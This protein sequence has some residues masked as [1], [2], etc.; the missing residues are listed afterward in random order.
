MR[1]VTDV[2][3]RAED[4][5]AQGRTEFEAGLGDGRGRPGA[6]GGNGVENGGSGNGAGYT[7]ARADQDQRNGE[8]WV[9]REE[10]RSHQ[11]QESESHDHQAAGTRSASAEA[12]YEPSDEN[13]NGNCG[14]RI[15]QL[16]QAGPK[17]R[18]FAHELEVLAEEVPQP[19]QCEDSHD[20]GQYRPGECRTREE[21]DID[22]RC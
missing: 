20:G 4:C 9:S 19:G 12:G 7:N 13:N 6:A 18:V 16:C 14:Y 10:S 1:T 8:W 15:R 3:N 5:N 22:K 11:S 2:L 21:S 17:S